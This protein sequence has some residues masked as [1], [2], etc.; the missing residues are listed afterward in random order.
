V[1]QPAVRPD[2][3]SAESG[4]DQFTRLDVRFASPSSA[5]NSAAMRDALAEQ[6]ASLS[7][8]A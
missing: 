6:P 3:T 1:L 5:P 4:R 2:H 7:S 8:S